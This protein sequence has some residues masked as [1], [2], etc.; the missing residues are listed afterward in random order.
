MSAQPKFLQQFSRISNDDDQNILPFLDFGEMNGWLAN[1][2]INFITITLL[3]QGY[4]DPQLGANYLEER[5][6][7]SKHMYTCYIKE[8]FIQ[9]M[10]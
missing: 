8:N 1:C 10:G 6:H 2:E 5:N 4:N 9:G 7:K 3:N